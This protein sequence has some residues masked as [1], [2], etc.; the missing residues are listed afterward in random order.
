MIK[1]QIYGSG[2]SGLMELCSWSCFPKSVHP[3]PLEI[4]FLCYELVILPLCFSHSNW[5]RSSTPDE[6]SQS[7]VRLNFSKEKFLWC[8]GRF[9]VLNSGQREEWMFVWNSPGQFLVSFVSFN[10]TK[11]PQ[12]ICFCSHAVSMFFSSLTGDQK[13]VGT[14]EELGNDF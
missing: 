12:I 4:Q 2:G 5:I 6:G 1:F 10:Y 11:K 9:Q 7:L 14:K 13:S 8:F 3:Y